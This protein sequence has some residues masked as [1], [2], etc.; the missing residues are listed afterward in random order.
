MTL[1]YRPS[2]RC[3]TSIH[4]FLHALTSNSSTVLTARDGSGDHSNVTFPSDVLGSSFSPVDSHKYTGGNQTSPLQ[5]SSE[6]LVAS[7][8]E[9]DARNTE[10]EEFKELVLKSE[11]SSLCVVS[12]QQKLVVESGVTETEPTHLSLSRRLKESE[13]VAASLRQK[14]AEMK[15]EIETG[16]AQLEILSQ[17]NIGVEDKLALETEQAQILVRDK[18]LINKDCVQLSAEKVKLLEEV[19]KL[20]LRMKELDGQHVEALGMVKRDFTQ[21]EV[22]LCQI[23]NQRTQEA[24]KLDSVLSENKMLMEE[25][26]QLRT[27]EVAMNSKL[28]DLQQQWAV[29]RQKMDYEQARRMKEDKCLKDTLSKC[30]SSSEELSTVRLELQEKEVSLSQ[31]KKEKDEAVLNLKAVQVELMDLKEEQSKVQIAMR[32]AK[33][34][35]SAQAQQLSIQLEEKEQ[36]TQRLSVQL[37]QAEHMVIDQN[38]AM[39]AEKAKFITEVKEMENK[40]ETEMEAC[41]TKALELENTLNIREL[42]IVDLEEKLKLAAVRMKEFE[43]LLAENEERALFSLRKDGEMENELTL[44]RS[45]LQKCRDESQRL[46]DKAELEAQI[47]QTEQESSLREMEEKRKEWSTERDHHLRQIMELEREVKELRRDL[48]QE[49]PRSPKKPVMQRSEISSCTT[50]VP[51]VES[52]EM[53]TTITLH[54]YSMSPCMHVHM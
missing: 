9:K 27:T 41:R 30:T 47:H 14:V 7:P 44:V 8:T 16:A 43:I 52:L 38:S 36:Q 48:G 37:E 35:M 23:E 17:T 2:I 21:L 25:N 15:C 49:S 28:A 39:S 12:R 6:T 46:K 18:E 40:K 34:S 45:Q 22:E 32:N 26:Q 33:E 50:S 13:T 54:R 10:V 4:D 5:S 24:R 19:S 42:K 11:P 3:D 53:V 20:K 1:H 31:C 29:E 51:S